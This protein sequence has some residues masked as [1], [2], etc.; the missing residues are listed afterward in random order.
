M[1]RSLKLA[2]TA[3]PLHAGLRAFSAASAPKFTTTEAYAPFLAEYTPRE[4]SYA[5]TQALSDAMYAEHAI[6]PGQDLATSATMRRMEVFIRQLQRTITG[7]LEQIESENPSPAC[8]HTHGRAGRRFSFE[9]HARDPATGMRGGG[10]AAVLQDGAVWEKAGVNVSIMSGAMQYRALQNMRA[11]HKALDERLRASG[12]ADGAV[13]PF[14]VSGI[15]LVLHPHSPR[16][17]TVHA[18][19]RLFELTV[20]GAPVWWFGGGADLTPT[21]VH[22][23]DARHFHSVLRQ[24]SDAAEP[25]AAAAAAGQPSGSKVLFPR[26]KSWADEYFRIPHRDNECRGIGGIFFDDLDSAAAGGAS[27]DELFRYVTGCGDAFC[28]AYFPLVR[29]HAGEAFTEQER[30]FQQ[31]RRGRYVEFNVMYDRGTKFGLQM[32][33]SAEVKT[34]SILMSLPL[35][36]RYEYRYEPQGPAE[37]RT[38]DILRN[39]VDWV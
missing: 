27:Q 11:D 34:E 30:R 9:P 35:T 31:L 25:A 7:H 38:M 26:F 1:L 21:L 3:S 15:S 19:F 37:T 2:R 17:P 23:A 39:P 5:R 4:S 33:R 14:A 12:A 36:A 22:D 6:A 10:V 8:L 20:A 13:F 18:N 24:A 32:P 28:A 29:A 16:A